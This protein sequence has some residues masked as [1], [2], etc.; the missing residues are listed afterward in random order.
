MNIL[1]RLLLADFNINYEPAIY[2]NA[3]IC[4]KGYINV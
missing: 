3:Y 2:C 4:R 1:E